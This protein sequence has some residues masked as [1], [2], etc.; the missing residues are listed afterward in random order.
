MTD[1]LLKRMAALESRLSPIAIRLGLPEVTF[2][3]QVNNGALVEDPE[4]GLFSLAPSDVVVTALLSQVPTPRNLENLEAPW[5]N[6]AAIYVTGHC[7]EPSFLPA[8]I[9]PGQI[10]QAILNY[11]DYPIA[12]RFLLLPALPSDSVILGHHIRGILLLNPGDNE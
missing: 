1:S 10:A 2:T 12:G 6:P 4:T 5:I 8:S 9:R 11:P 3:F 7:I